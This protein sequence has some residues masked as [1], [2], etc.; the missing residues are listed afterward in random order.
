MKEKNILMKKIV[1]MIMLSALLTGTGCG[2]RS[3]DTDREENFGAEN[4]ETREG[5]EDP[6]SFV[7]VTSKMQELA[8][9]F[10]AVR[11]E[12]DYGFE[13]FLEQGGA[14][15]DQAVLQFLAS[16]LLAEAAGLEMNTGFFGCSTLSVEN[17]AGGYLFGRNFDWQ[18]CD[19]LVVAA[20]PETGY[21]SISTVN[22]NFIRQGAGFASSFLSDEILTAAALYAPLDGMNEKGLCV[23]VNMI[24]DGA[25]IQQNTEKPDITTTTA[26]R[27]LLDQA[28]TVEEALELLKQYDLHA[29]MNYMVHFAIADSVGSSVAVEYIDNKMIVTETPVL[30]NFYLAEGEK[31]GIG[32]QQSHTRFEILTE[33]LKENQTMTQAQVRDALDSV[34]KDNFGEFEST[35]WS[36]VFDQSALTSTYYHRENYEEAYSFQLAVEQSEK[37]Q[38][39]AAKD[40]GVSPEQDKS[41]QTQQSEQAGN[42]GLELEEMS[43]LMKIDDETV[44]VTWEDN[45]A[46]AALKELLRKQPLSIQMSMYGG[47]EQVGPLGADLPRKDTQTITQ[48]GDIVLYS[49]DQIVVFYGSNSWAYTRLGKITDKS[50]RELE[51]L[52]GGGDVTVVL[53]LASQAVDAAP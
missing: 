2:S 19:A 47:F 41:A 30:T 4:T 36:I 9:G 39:N 16:G 37:T 44:A 7:P 3:S 52:L 49:G 28:A 35:E 43:I 31:Q 27:L 14:D 25:T 26:I 53:E 33:S 34:S 46:V 11:Y 29:S 32:T 45:E 24:Q 51:G 20:Y 10:S 17:T 6:L 15:S 38:G 21:A 48:A 13:R 1:L 42:A 18:A 8:S 50:D 5:T 22:L 23:S 12:G 40:N